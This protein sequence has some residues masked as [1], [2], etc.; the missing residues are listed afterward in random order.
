MV[1][2][3]KLYTCQKHFNFEFYLSL[4]HYIFPVFRFLTDFVCLHTYEF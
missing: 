4:Y 3:P 1:K 2:E